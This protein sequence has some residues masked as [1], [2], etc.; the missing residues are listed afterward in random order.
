M[1]KFRASF[2]P[3][4]TVQRRTRDASRR[5]GNRFGAYVRTVA[6]RSIRKSKRSS[7]P[8][9]P[10][11]NRTGS[12][13]NFIRFAYE[14]AERR[15]YIGPAILPGKTKSLPGALE[16][17][18]TV[19]VKNKKTKKRVKQKV[20]ARPYMLP[21]LEESLPQLPELWKNSIR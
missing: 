7:L 10:P 19:V 2:T 8:G 3:T 15:V 12:L 6:R 21:A 20:A 13:R 18:G 17:G 4:R 1:I 9:S 11:R 16:L 14:P 5:V